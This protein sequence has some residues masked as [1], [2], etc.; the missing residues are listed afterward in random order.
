MPAGKRPRV[1]FV[2]SDHVKQALERWAEDEDKT[3]SS[4]LDELIKEV[5][6]Q[7]GYLEPPKKLLS[8]SH[9]KN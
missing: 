3:V 8:H 7:K 9:H 2:T 1:M 5:L 4:L 6:V